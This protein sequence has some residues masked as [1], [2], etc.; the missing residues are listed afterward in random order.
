[1]IYKIVLPFTVKTRLG[2]VSL[3]PGQIVN[4]SEVKA[5]KLIN[6]GKI[7]LLNEPKQQLEPQKPAIRHC[8]PT[9]PNWELNKRI[10][11]PDMNPNKYKC[12][13]CNAIAGRY[14]FGQDLN[15]K[16]LWGWMCLKCRPYIEPERN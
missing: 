3:N 6:E 12:L 1:M 10:G 11:L 5:V 9:Q 8:E 2:D 7:K 15:G 16:W 4:L 13:Q 14:C